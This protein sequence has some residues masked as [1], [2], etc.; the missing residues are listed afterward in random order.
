M[1]AT[2]INQPGG[3]A[4]N[5]SRKQ[6]TRSKR[7]PSYYD[8]AAIAG[9]RKLEDGRGALEMTLPFDPAVALEEFVDSLV[10]LV[11]MIAIGA[12]LETDI[13]AHAGRKHA[14]LDGRPAWRHGYEEG[15]IGYNGKRLGIRRPPR[16]R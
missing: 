13:E 9:L 4:M 14:H 15:W 3:T 6:S 5:K 10:S 12:A 2:P 16:A 7:K 1:V 11:G 8:P